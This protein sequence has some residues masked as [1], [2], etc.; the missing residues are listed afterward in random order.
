ML[1]KS[2]MAPESKPHGSETAVY[3]QACMFLSKLNEL[4]WLWE[5]RPQDSY[6]SAIIES[7]DGSGFRFHLK[8]NLRFK[9]I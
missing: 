7:H 4:I 8:D 3:L 1:T 6:F 9:I 5:A 2:D